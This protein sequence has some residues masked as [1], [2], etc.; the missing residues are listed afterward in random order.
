MK[1]RPPKRCPHCG[2]GD[3]AAFGKN[4]SRPD[5][6]QSWCRV[7]MNEWGSASR[8]GKKK[9]AD[10]QRRYFLKRKYGITEQA[11]A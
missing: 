6:L 10:Y 8:K 1:V 7:C 2:T 5:G 3:L 4:R 9:Y 11:A